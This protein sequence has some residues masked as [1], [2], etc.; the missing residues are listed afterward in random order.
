MPE[1]SP[2]PLEP[3]QALPLFI[4]NV[5]DYAL[6]L[7]DPT[8]NI[9]SWN[10]GVQFIKGYAADEVI[11]RH[12]SCFYPPEDIAAG[13][14]QRHLEHAAATGRCEDIG[15]RVRKDG[16]RFLANV[17][18]TA[19]RSP[20][21][22]LLGFAKVTRDLTDR[23]MTEER[24]SASERRL[25]TLVDTLLDMLVDGLITINR[26]G[27]I[28]SY[29]KACVRLFGYTVDEVLG[30]NVNMLM[31]EPD[32]G[33][34]DRYLSDYLTTGNA[35]II[36]IGRDVFGQRKDGSVFPM[37]LAV[38]ETT[39]TGA[40]AFVG[41][42]HD[43]TEQ[44][45]TQERLRD[46]EAQLRHSQR[47]EA[48]G[49]LTGGMAHD[50]NNLLSVIVGAIEVLIDSLKD[51]PADLEL[52]DEILKSAL[53]GAEL[54]RRLLAFA[55]RQ[56][57]RPAPLDLNE[58]LPPQ[59]ELLRHTLGEAVA[60]SAT[61]APGLWLTHA[62]PSQVGDALLNLAIN[63]RD[64][65]P[66]GGQLII[67]TGNVHLDQDTAAQDNE[68]TAGDYVILSVT[69]TGGGMSQ[70][71][72]AHAVEPF[73]TTKAP[74][75][76]TGLGLS[77][78]YGFAKQS[79]GQL[80]IHSEVGVGTRVGL[81]L[82]RSVVTDIVSAAEAV[83]ATVASPRGTESILLVD[84]NAA[85]RS[86]GARHLT[87]LGYA[88]RVAENGLAALDI[89]RSNERF[90]LLFTDVLM[91]G[92]MTGFQLAEVARRLRPG[93]AVLFTTGY[94]P[95]LNGAGADVEPDL[96]LHKPYLRHQL[97]EKIRSALGQVG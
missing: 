42:I 66:A 84:D 33:R 74:G 73:F 86:V 32:R 16:S 60:V 68:V 88:V 35:A 61:L 51:R 63:A 45:R 31:P 90:D 14:P 75:A 3:A 10:Q 1:V 9:T 29:N 26:R 67:E 4:D 21:G 89:L 49:Q 40:H 50:F 65:M 34:H 97:A 25:R 41:I 17:I 12:W 53:S 44:R 15:Y 22:D 28:Q 48:I 85:V 58:Y 2:S 47:M 64:A 7:L 24:V 13:K 83:A 70:E 39:D 6:V 19:V 54:T 11:G 8:G 82:P 69:D 94:T 27:E 71:V 72:V 18:L 91:P 96:I 30:R 20:D 93:I 55:R 92:G 38:G 57:L 5:R 46:S 37:R 76:G 81:Y 79:G 95:Q 78:I 52:A 56:P 77:M 62:D 36:G 59:I 43:L 87:T 23:I 80:E